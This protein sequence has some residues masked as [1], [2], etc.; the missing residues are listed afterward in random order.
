MMYIREYSTDEI[1]KMPDERIDYLTSMDSLH[2]IACQGGDLVEMMTLIEKID[3]PDSDIEAKMLLYK[4]S[5]R[6]FGR[7]W[8]SVL[9]FITNYKRATE[10]Q[11]DRMGA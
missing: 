7:Y 2:T 5:V 3:I 11:N 6:E 10:V 1:K 9:N 8:G 4:I